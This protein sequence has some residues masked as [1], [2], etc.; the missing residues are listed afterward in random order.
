MNKFANPRLHCLGDL[1]K[2]QSW[3]KTTALVKHTTISITVI[4]EYRHN[5]FYIARNLRIVAKSQ[6]SQVGANA[7]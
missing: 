7:N 4:N 3:K 2:D 5:K 6:D 1:I